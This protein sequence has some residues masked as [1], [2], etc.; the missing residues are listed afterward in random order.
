MPDGATVDLTH[1]VSRKSVRGSTSAVVH[2]GSRGSVGIVGGVINGGISPSATWEGAGGSGYGLDTYVRGRTTVSRLRVHGVRDAFRPRESSADDRYSFPNTGSWR[3]EDSYFTQLADDAV[4][5]DEFM[6]GEI[7]DSLFDGVYANVSEQSQGDGKDVT[8]TIGPRESKTVRI[9]N[10]LIRLDGADGPGK[11]F[12][13]MAAD[14]AEQHVHTISNSI[15]AISKEPRLGWDDVDFEKARWLGRNNYILWLGR[16][17][18]GGVKPRGV[19]LLSGRAARKKWTTERDRWLR[20]H[21]LPPRGPRD[22]NSTDD[23]VTPIRASVTISEAQRQGSAARPARHERRAEPARVTP[24]TTARAGSARRTATLLVAGDIVKKAEDARA[25]GGLIARTSPDLFVTTG[26]N[27]YPD[28]SDEDYQKYDEGLGRY[29]HRTLP[30]A[31]NHDHHSEGARPMLRY[32]GLRKLWNSRDVGPVR[33]IGV[34]SEFPDDPGQLAWL[35]S[36]LRT[37]K[38]VVV[39]WHKPRYSSSRHGSSSDVGPLWQAALGKADVVVNGHDHNYERF[40]PRKGTREIVI[41]TGGASAYDFGDRESGSVVRHTGTTGGL[42]LT[43]TG[44]RYVAQFLPIDG[45]FS[46]RFSGTCRRGRG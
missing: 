29:K 24:A 27:A 8:D 15:I 46:D 9:T 36:Q 6:P 43:F 16:G 31:G 33:V 17:S 10:S 44:N 26:D 2:V 32:F 30:V 12:K 5:N 21:G 7:D 25:M 13:L 1:F 22:L 42:K 41:G 4:E 18:F 37:N 20:R 40:A 19:K 11:A 3:L 38:C 35:K 45:S 34:D 28:G 39:S 23:P 14:G